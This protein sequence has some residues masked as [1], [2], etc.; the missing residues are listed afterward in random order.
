MQNTTPTE[1]LAL[2]S[3]HAG[4]GQLGKDNKYSTFFHKSTMFGML[5]G[6]TGCGEKS[7][8]AREWRVCGRKV[9]VGARRY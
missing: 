8:R 1:S 5:E 2:Q 9:W 4:L 7:R 6:D 3:T